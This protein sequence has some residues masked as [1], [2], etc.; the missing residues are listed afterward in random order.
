MK[1]LTGFA[2]GLVVFLL[3]FYIIDAGLMKAQGLQLFADE[4]TGEKE[5]SGGH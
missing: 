5:A 1:T 2:A 3:F 4:K